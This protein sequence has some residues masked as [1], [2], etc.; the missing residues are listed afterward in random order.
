MLQNPEQ[1]VERGTDFMAHVGEKF[2][3]CT[4]GLFGRVFGGAQFLL[5]TDTF[6]NVAQQYLNRRLTMP[7][8]TTSGG[9]NVNNGTIKA[10][11]ALMIRRSLLFQPQDTCDTLTD[12]RMLILFNEIKGGATDDG[13]HSGGVEK[14]A[15]G[16]IGVDKTSTDIDQDGIGRQIRQGAIPLLALLQRLLRL[17]ADADFAQGRYKDH[18]VLQISASHVDLTPEQ[19]TI[20]TT[21]PPF[22]THRFSLGSPFHPGSGFLLSVGRLVFTEIAY[23][24][25]P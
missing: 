6:G 20:A 9:L 22:K 11:P 18:F 15:R 13:I 3:F 16:R 4:G 12:L 21:R 8:N 2:A 1:S 19:G 17:T 14:I 25:G 24:H 7:G 5:I 23:R 10:P